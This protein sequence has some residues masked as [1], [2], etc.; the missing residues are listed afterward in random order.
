MSISQYPA[1]LFPHLSSQLSISTSL[2]VTLIILNIHRG[3][4]LTIPALGCGR[5]APEHIFMLDCNKIRMHTLI[6]ALSKKNLV[7]KKYAI[8]FRHHRP[9]T[10]WEGINIQI[11]KYRCT[12]YCNHQLYYCLCNVNMH[13]AYMYV[14]YTH[15]AIYTDMICMCNCTQTK[16]SS[17][18]LLLTYFWPKTRSHPSTFEDLCSVITH[19]SHL[20]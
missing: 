13:T 2:P 9:W 12:K 6:R 15:I 4:L 5:E 16:C 10:T 18:T 7:P 1:C 11:D 8:V 19:G 17:S 20:W 3:Q 14:T